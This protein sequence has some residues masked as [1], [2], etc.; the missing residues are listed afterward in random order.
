MAHLRDHAAGF[1]GQNRRQ[2]KAEIYGG[3]E[4]LLGKKD[5]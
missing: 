3:V 1:S 2:K 5:A 4:K